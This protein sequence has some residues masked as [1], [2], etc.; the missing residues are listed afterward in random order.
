[1]AWCC[2]SCRVAQMAGRMGLSMWIGIAVVFFIAE[3]MN[4][5]GTSN[6][7]APTF[8]ATCNDW[9]RTFYPELRNANDVPKT[10]TFWW[11][12][13]RPKL[14]AKLIIKAA[15]A[16]VGWI[17]MT[18]ALTVV[19][20]AV[21]NKYQIHE[22]ALISW[23]LSCFCGFCTLYQVSAE[24]DFSERGRLDSCS[25]DCKVLGPV[26]S[27]KVLPFVTTRC[28]FVTTP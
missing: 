5:W 23:V 21:V 7:R 2:A 1:M 13:C 20:R 4:V 25:A 11:D 6:D 12:E 28:P 16:V 27:G 24:V 22:T 19:R 10:D 14:I 8:D 9:F 15:V 3:G 18:I 17:G 26:F